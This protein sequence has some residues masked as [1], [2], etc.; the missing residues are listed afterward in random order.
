MQGANLNKSAT[1]YVPRFFNHCLLHDTHMQHLFLVTQQRSRQSTRTGPR[2]SACR[3]NWEQSIQ[4]LITVMQLTFYDSR[5]S[6][7]CTLVSHIYIFVVTLA[8]LAINKIP[9]LLEMPRLL[10]TW[11]SA[12]CVYVCE[13]I[14]FNSVAADA[15]RAADSAHGSQQ[16]F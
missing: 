14:F 6:F 9:H 13:L 12:A 3:D 1:Y 10:S 8:A 5:G 7:V 11:I 4:T 2:H 16:C 15:P